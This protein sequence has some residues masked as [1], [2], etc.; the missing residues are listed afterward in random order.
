MLLMGFYSFANTECDQLTH[1]VNDPDLQSHLINWV[2]N[3]L[4]DNYQLSQ[5][6]TSVYQVKPGVFSLKNP[7]F[8]WSLLEDHDHRSRIVLIGI[9]HLDL[10]REDFTVDSSL[11]NSVYFMLKINVGVMI[12]TQISDE[13]IDASKKQHLEIISDRVAVYCNTQGRAPD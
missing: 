3:N 4:A 8:D 2:D 5:N 10:S 7:N 12:K 9:D 1:V 6:I 13:F 11:V